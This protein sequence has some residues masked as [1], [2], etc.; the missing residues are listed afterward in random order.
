[1]LVLTHWQHPCCTG[2][3]PQPMLSHLGFNFLDG[4]HGLNIHIPLH[5]S[6]DAKVWKEALRMAFR[7]ALSK[8]TTVIQLG[9]SL[10][11]SCFP[12]H[13]RKTLFVLSSLRLQLPSPQT[14]QHLCL[15]A[16][17]PWTSCLQTDSN[18][19]PLLIDQLPLY[20]GMEGE[21][22]GAYV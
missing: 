6:A 22:T 7:A 21:H 12:P 1:M 14:A 20:V 9:L 19:F 10:T 18:T 11:S 16:P 17:G 15:L 8:G 3:G 4:Y 5:C 2:C 13:V